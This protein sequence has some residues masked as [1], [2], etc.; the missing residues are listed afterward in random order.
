MRCL[1]RS[2]NNAAYL[3]NMG[4]VRFSLSQG[5]IWVGGIHIHCRSW[6]SPSQLEFASVAGFNLSPEESYFFL[7]KN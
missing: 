3:P 6:P 1:P 2:P 4:G 5:Q 7:I